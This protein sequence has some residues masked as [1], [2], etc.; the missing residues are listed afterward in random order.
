MPRVAP[1]WTGGPIAP[2]A[3]DPL[4]PTR[5][6]SAPRVVS[7]GDAAARWGAQALALGATLLAFYRAT[8]SGVKV[9]ALRPALYV[10]FGWAVVGHIPL[11]LL[12]AHLGLV[13]GVLLS[14]GA[15]GNYWD[16]RLLGE[17]NSTQAV[18]ERWRLS[19]PRALALTCL[20]GLGTLPWYW[21]ALRSGWSGLSQACGWAIVLLGLCH[22]TPPLRLKTRRLG[23]LTPLIAWFLLFLEAYTVQG[24]TLLAPTTIFLAGCVW[25]FQCQAEI[26][27]LLDDRLHSAREPVPLSPQQ[28]QAWLRR[29]P[30]MAGAWSV[31]AAGVHPVFLNSTAWWIV[32]ARALR[33]ATPE[34]LCRA[35]RQLWHPV[36]SLYEFGIYAAIGLMGRTL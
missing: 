30:W 36:W 9:S 13:A 19:P 17:R 35:R 20:P 28:L 1:S 22:I 34:G 7:W 31:A 27:H 32:R 16:W 18:M 33:R 29:L 24:R 2:A 4:A 10:L 14:F 25:W 26:L 15:Y 11:P 21:L 23:Y 8:T 3:A 6:G 12:A 5:P